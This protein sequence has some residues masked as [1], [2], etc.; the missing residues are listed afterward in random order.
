M[1]SDHPE[2]RVQSAKLTCMF[3]CGLGGTLFIYQGQ[4]MG[5]CNVPRDW[6]EEE[7]KDIETIQNL[8]GE[9]DHRR[10]KTGEEDPD[11]SDYL[12]GIRET[13]RDNGRT[14]IQVSG[15]AGSSCR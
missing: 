8:E 3:H 1:A 4:E 2:D 9:R 14:P 11:M 15:C 12:Q 6:K 5:L 10:R 13:A 7:Y